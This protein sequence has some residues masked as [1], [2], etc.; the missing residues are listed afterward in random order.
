MLQQDIRERSEYRYLYQSLERPGVAKGVL[1][2]TGIKLTSVSRDKPSKLRWRSGA[3]VSA[4][5]P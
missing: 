4:K 5:M 1:G 3:V 2:S